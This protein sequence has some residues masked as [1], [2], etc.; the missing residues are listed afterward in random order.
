M[1]K[2]EKADIDTYLSPLI[3]IILNLLSYNL[4]TGSIE[5]FI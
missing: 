4:L 2:N 5:N 1:H 3:S